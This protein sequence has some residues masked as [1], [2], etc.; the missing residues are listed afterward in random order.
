[1]K[2]VLCLYF[3]VSA[4]LPAQTAK[5]EAVYFGAATIPHQAVPLFA[6]GD[7][8][9]LTQPNRL[10]VFRPD[11][12][13]AFEYD[14]PCPPQTNHCSVSSV[15]VA[16]KG[17]VA[18]GIGYGD[19]SSGIRF[20]DEAGK[21]TRFVST[22]RYVPRQLTFDNNGDLWSIGWERDELVN[23]TASK[24]SYNI[25]RKY[26]AEG[27]LKGEFL[28]RSLW[29]T[30]D[31][32]HLGGRGYWTVYAAADRIGAVVNE[33]FS[34]RTP[35]W[36][37]WDLNGAI[38]RRV[39]LVGMKLLGRAFDIEGRLYSKFPVE[40][41]SSQ[42]ELRVLEDGSSG[43]WIPVRTNLPD[44]MTGFLLGADGDEL[45]YRVSG[46]GNVHLVWSRPD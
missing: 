39:P 13:L 26:S 14:V 25:V 46:P 34:G 32:P 6:N 19:F 20:L 4:A 17:V 31:G 24:G 23:D 37:E 11:T 45:V 40:G 36:V 44:P 12:Q 10:Q 15:A 9:Y 35:E 43:K 5:R 27:T 3:F 41:H 22:G 21:E 29:E 8:I 30:K 38:L 2:Y 33:S 42:T 28:P 16:R 7:L 1:M 18:L